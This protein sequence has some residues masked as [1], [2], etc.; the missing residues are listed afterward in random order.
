MLNLLN[1]SISDVYKRQVLRPWVIAVRRYIARMDYFSRTVE[2]GMVNIKTIVDKSYRNILAEGKLMGHIGADSFIDPDAAD[3]C[4]HQV[5][6]PGIDLF[7]S[8][9][10]DKLRMT[11]LLY[12]S[13]CV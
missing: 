2:L 12:T 13:R 10:P 5:P 3:S 1:I 8:P 9:F 6:L 7:Q 11:C 4:C